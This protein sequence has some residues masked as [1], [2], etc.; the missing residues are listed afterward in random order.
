MG[1]ETAN[2]ESVR[3]PT[4]LELGFSALKRE[5]VDKGICSLCGT[6]VAFCDKIVIEAGE[7]KT[8][9]LPE[10]VE[11]YDTVCGLCYTFCP[12]TLLP[13]AELERRILGKENA[14]EDVLGVYRR[15]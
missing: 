8:A 6:C 5:V 12:R 13:L 10:F 3:L 9:E 14:D 4:F 11:G 1:T 7:S 15:D 2:R